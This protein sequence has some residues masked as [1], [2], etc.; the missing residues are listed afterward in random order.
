MD[1]DQIADIGAFV[2]CTAAQLALPIEPDHRPI[3]IGVMTRL[4]AYGADLIAH[5]LGLD[6]E[7]AGVFIP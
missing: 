6:V 5:D 4:A 1:A 3:V 2:D 7:I